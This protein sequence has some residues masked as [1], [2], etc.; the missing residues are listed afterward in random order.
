MANG[1]LSLVLSLRRLWHISLKRLSPG[2]T[3]AA[4]TAATATTTTTRTQTH[5]CQTPGES[6]RRSLVRENGQPT[7]GTGSGKWHEARAARRARR[8][9]GSEPCWT[10]GLKPVRRWHS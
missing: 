5:H 9:L 1:S 8:K 7:A 4:I 6:Y 10:V 3:R 2:P